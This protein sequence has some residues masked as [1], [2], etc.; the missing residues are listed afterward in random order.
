[1]LSRG[2]YVILPE[3]CSTCRY[4]A[5]NCQFSWRFSVSWEI[6]MSHACAGIWTS[7]PTSI[8]W[9]VRQRTMTFRQQMLWRMFV[10]GQ[11]CINQKRQVIIALYR[12]TYNRDWR[13][14]LS[15]QQLQHGYISRH[16]VWSYSLEFSQ[17]CILD[18]ARTIVI[19]LST[20]D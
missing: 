10:A 5:S 13:N 16:I 7:L 14:I 2:L 11:I 3:S 9:V 6:Q 4:H 19:I 18:V 15:T 17:I 20:T 8:P 12:Q 1:M